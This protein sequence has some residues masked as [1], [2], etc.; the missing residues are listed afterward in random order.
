MSQQ[1]RIGDAPV[2]QRI[3]NYIALVVSHE[4]L[5]ESERRA[6]AGVERRSEESDASGGDRN[7]R[8][9]PG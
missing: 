1:R 5:A 8:A 3:G 2:A 7:N 9:T 4:Q 6:V